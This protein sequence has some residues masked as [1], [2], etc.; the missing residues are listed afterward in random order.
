MTTVAFAEAVWVLQG[1]RYA[2]PR[3]HIREAL[4]DIARIENLEVPELA[5]ILE[6]LD[7]YAAY[8]IDFADGYQTAV[9]RSLGAEL[10]SFD[11]DFDRIPGITR[12]EP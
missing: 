6:A 10:Y 4:A 9:A 2:L 3:E 8:K 1:P 7:L 5:L 11:R 12:I